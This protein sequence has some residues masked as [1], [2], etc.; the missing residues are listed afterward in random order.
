MNETL[1]WDEFRL[2]KAISDSGSLGGAA[3]IL[4]LN[5]STVFRRLAALETTVGARLFERSREGYQPTVAGDEMIAV[6]TTMADSIIGFE[7][8]LAGRDLRPSGQLRVTTAEAIGQQILPAIMA[9]FRAQNSGVVIELK[10]SNQMLNL[11]RRDADVAIRLTNDPP[12]SPGRA[13]TLR[14]PIGH[15][16]SARPRLLARIPAARFGAVRRVWRQVRPDC[17]A[18]LDRGSRPSGPARRQNQLNPQPCASSRS[19]ASG[20]RC[21]PASSATSAR[22]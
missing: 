21:C 7:R 2:V 1:S 10:L 15:L 9:Q 18:A 17:G 5:H 16:L 4:G 3:E 19:R 13:K 22:P 6:A 14:R 11:S 20:R 12:E 8:K